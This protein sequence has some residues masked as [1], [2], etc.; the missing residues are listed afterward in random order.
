EPTSEPGFYQTSQFTPRG[1]FEPTISSAFHWQG[2]GIT[3]GLTLHETFYGQSLVNGAVSSAAI[4]RTAPELNIDFALP[5]IERVF[6]RKTFLGDKLKHVIEPRISYKYV[7]GVDDFFNTLRFDQFDLLTDTNELQIGIT[8]RIYAKK[9]NTVNEVFTWELYQTRYFNPTFGGALEPGSRNVAASTLDL[10]GFSFLNGPRNYSP[11]V[12]NVRVS[13]RPGVGIQWQADYDPLLHRLANSMVSADVRYKKYFI[14]AGHNLVRPDP[15][16]APPAN[17][18]RAQVGYGDP[19]RKGWNAA[20]STIYD[21][22]LG[23]QEFAVAQV[24][25][26]TDCCGFSVEYRRF[27]IGAARDDTSY[28]FAFSIANIGTF[29]NLKKQ[30]RLF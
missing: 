28:R 24:T 17:Q 9:G 27:N 8:N 29:G 21:Y 4:N 26:N 20:V 25:Y 16:V 30:E 6:D 22:R 7:T 10:T 2:L 1:D 13:P 5:P 18:V 23:I 12:S 3:P 14:S 19:N 15:V 11:I